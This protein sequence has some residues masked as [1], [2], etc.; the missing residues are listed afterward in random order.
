MSL[1]SLQWRKLPT[2]IT[3]YSTTTFTASLILDTI[4][5]MLT[6]S[7]YFDG[8]TRIAGSGS[9]WSASAKFQTGSNTEAVICR[10]PVYTVIS[11]SIILSATNHYGP[12]SSATPFMCTGEV[13]SGSYIYMACVKNASASFTEWTSRFPFGS[14]SYSTGYGKI[15]GTAHMSA[16]ERLTVYESK[17]ALAV[18]FSNPQFGGIVLTAIGG[19]IIDPEQNTTSV[20]AEIDGR[21]YAIATS[22]VPITAGYG[23]APVFLIEGGSQSGSL[24]THR[25]E[26]SAA[27]A[28]YARFVGFYPQQQASMSIITQKTGFTNVAGY[29]PYYVFNTPY[30][31]KL[32]QNPIL[33]AISGSAT[34]LNYY[35]GRLRDINITK[36]LPSNQ[37]VRDSSGSISGFTL[38]YS[39]NTVTNGNTVLFP[40]N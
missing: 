36:A 22:G 15:S 1:P 18:M 25:N 24:F 21:L 8:S 14:G 3:P 34:N 40:Y 30:S 37:V 6:G 39:E 10:P 28:G 33:C 32:I 38:A 7:V 16:G 20:D 12:S 4:Y 2:R 5:D 9:A 31:G 11:Q 26:A 27:G 19:A 35:L 17:E 23:V 29:N 13:Y